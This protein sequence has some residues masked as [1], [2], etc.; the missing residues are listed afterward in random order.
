MNV[1]FAGGR[2]PGKPWLHEPA[3]DWK[4]EG[5]CIIASVRPSAAVKDPAEESGTFAERVSTPNEAIA[6]GFAL[7]MT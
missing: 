7:A 2:R 4:T 6:S 1:L 3:E 5:D